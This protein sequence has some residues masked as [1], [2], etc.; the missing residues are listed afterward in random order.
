MAALLEPLKQ[1]KSLFKF[2]MKIPCYKWLMSIFMFIFFS[3]WIKLI[4]LSWR[5][6]SMVFFR[7]VKPSS[8]RLRYSDNTFCQSISCDIIS[9]FDKIMKKSNLSVKELCSWVLSN[10]SCCLPTDRFFNPRWHDCQYRRQVR[11]YVNQNE[12][13]EADQAHQGNLSPV[14]L[15]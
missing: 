4:F 12:D 10:V 14:D 15:I 8:W 5:W 13:P 1:Q 3:L 2:K 9:A 6:L 11:G 7:R